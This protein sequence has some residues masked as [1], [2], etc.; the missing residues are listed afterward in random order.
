VDPLRG[1]RYGTYAANWA[2]GICMPVLDVWTW[3]RWDV[4]GLGLT[5]GNAGLLR[6]WVV[7]S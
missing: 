3:P 7:T 2:Y 4:P 6:G 1:T 5:D